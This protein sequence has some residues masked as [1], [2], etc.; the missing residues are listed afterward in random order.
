MLTALP[1]LV[2]LLFALTLPQIVPAAE[3]VATAPPPETAS[4]A[5]VP[6]ARSATTAAHQTR[7]PAAKVTRHEIT[8][9]GRTLAF[10]A[11]ASAVTLTSPS[12]RD[13][14]DLAFVA[15]TL[16]STDR[17]NR[18]VTFLVNGG[19]GA[20][21]AYLQIG[22]IGPW[23][24]P[25]DGDRIVPSGPAALVPNEDTWLDF[26]DLVF[27]DPVGTGFSRLVDPNDRLRS[28]YLSVEG[29]ARIIA[30]AIADWL[31]ANDRTGSP[32]YF[33]GESYGGFRGPLV[34]Q[35][36]RDDQG[37]ALSGLTLISPVLDFGWWQQPEYAPLPAVAI[38]PSLAAAHMES[39][40]RFSQA[41]LEA[42]EDYAAGEFL[43]DLMRGVED[44]AALERLTSRV[45]ALT[46]MDEYAVAREDGRIDAGEFARES[47]SEEHLRTS[48]Y[49]ATV[50]AAGRNRGSDPV[51]DAMTAPLSTAMLGLYRDTLGWLPNR[52]YELLNGSVTR[53]WNWGNHRGQPEAVSA[54]SDLITL[55]PALR[56]LISHGRT[57]L[58]TP[59]FGTTLILRQLDLSAARDRLSQVTYPGGHMFYTRPESRRAFRE[60]AMALYEDA[61]G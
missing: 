58:V 33:A 31:V 12:G 35:H 49:D 11:T 52:S 13:E 59:Y 48:V 4:P 15:Y 27:L 60:D 10:E 14:A 54:L 43:T 56:V 41:E 2:S 26:T 21:S 3:H 39:Q 50:T 45:T 47:R 1:R 28:R 17:V 57:D 53:G 23:L 6:R 44:G 38:L 9:P 32:K 16:D 42:A 18:P 46:G 37:F 8:L 25:L 51:L 20:A 7:L 22:A 29:D 40:G 34:A 36:L 30:Q 61:S 55:D 19:P 24:L 5:T